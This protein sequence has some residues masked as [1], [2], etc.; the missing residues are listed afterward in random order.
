MASGT[1]ADHYETLG[2]TPVASAA[3]IRRAYRRLALKHHPDR[4]QGNAK[5]TAAF[6]RVRICSSHPA[7]YTD[8]ACGVCRS[9][10]RGKP[11][12]TRAR[13]AYTMPPV[14][15]TLRQ[16]DQ[17]SQAL[18]RRRVARVNQRPNRPEHPR[19]LGGNRK[20]RRMTSNTKLGE[21]SPGHR[22]RR[23]T[24]SRYKSANLR[25]R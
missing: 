10:K 7:D 8:I 9:D 5:A 24:A 19:P 6:Q 11:Y 17:I 1:S 2:V 15:R 12:R 13:D 14:D 4:N 16:P 25:V 21:A 18:A 23:S 22:P 20:I 3:E